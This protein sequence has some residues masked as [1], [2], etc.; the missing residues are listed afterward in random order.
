M[1][2]EFKDETT[3]ARL[4]WWYE[5]GSGFRTESFGIHIS[6]IP[7]FKEWLSVGPPKPKWRITREFPEK[8]TYVHMGRNS[9][10]NRCFLLTDEDIEKVTE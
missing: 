2:E 7:A 8:P 9:Q 3:G 10:E 1:N 6:Q 5:D 4:A